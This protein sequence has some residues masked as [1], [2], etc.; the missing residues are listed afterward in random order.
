[1]KQK[2][3]LPLTGKEHPPKTLG[4]LFP[5]TNAPEQVKPLYTIMAALAT[6][7]IQAGINLHFD[8]KTVI[9]NHHW[10]LVTAEK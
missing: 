2:L 4:G 6:K 3:P 10:L 5:V 1:L 8:G 9:F 7:G